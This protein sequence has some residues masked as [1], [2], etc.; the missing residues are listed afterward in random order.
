MKITQIQL[1][2]FRNY[3]S[4]QLSLDSKIN[5]I[6]G[7][8][9]QG[10]TNLLE[11]IV[12]LS[13][14]RS[15][16]AMTDQDMIRQLQPFCRL[17]CQLDTESSLHLSAVIHEK[18]KTLM[19]AGQP[20]S[21]ATEFIGKLNA[22]L[23]APS[24]L[25]VFEAPPKVR[26]RNM[27][28]EI[29]KVSRKYMQFLGA[30]TKILKERNSLLKRDVV[31][32]NVLDVLDS[33]LLENEI[34]VLQIR[35]DFL[36]AMN[37]RITTYYQQLAQESSKIQVLYQTG[38]EKGEREEILVELREKRRNSR[39]RDCI[40]KT[41]SI[42]IHR[43]DYHFLIDDCDV[44]SY[45][46]QG[47]RRMIVLAWKLSLID[48]IVKS[49]QNYPVLLLDDVLSELDKEKRINL[50]SLIPSQVQSIIT[51]TEIEEILDSLPQKPTV[52]EVTNGQ[53]RPWKEEMN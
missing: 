7:K 23:F 37:D 26:R 24:D 30:Y 53:V 50:F 14:T 33:Q 31:D 21:R 20:V 47:Q 34:E 32:M 46:S 36:N 43:D 35:R 27:D 1:R 40:L 22:V 51:A 4:C 16:R 13:T 49:K 8:N 48:Y 45:A 6:I 3:E 10:K 52:F 38:S 25:E 15:H 2:N 28:I 41:T 29:G 18:G 44:V 19:I 9:A 17:E 42:G 5:V 39:Q 12:F 11:S